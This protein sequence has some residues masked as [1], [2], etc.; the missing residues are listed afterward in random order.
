MNSAQIATLRFCE[1]WITAAQEMISE[2]ETSLDMLLDRVEALEESAEQT[3]SEHESSR[4]ILLDHVE[5]L[6]ESAKNRGL[7]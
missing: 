2:H 1:D 4:K 6:E 7:G 5:A 3:I